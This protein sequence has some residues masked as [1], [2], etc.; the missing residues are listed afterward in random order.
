MIIGYF[1]STG[2]IFFAFPN[3]QAE[4]WS[5]TLPDSAAHLPAVKPPPFS[6][7]SLFPSLTAS[8]KILFCCPCFQLSAAKL[9][10]SPVEFVPKEALQKADGI[11]PQSAD[12]AGCS[13]CSPKWPG[14]SCG[15]VPF[16]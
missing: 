5:A 15:T 7:L 1:C 16:S 12:P 8:E 3:L 2:M 11:H 6:F 13:W 10:L 4:V 9:P 14:K